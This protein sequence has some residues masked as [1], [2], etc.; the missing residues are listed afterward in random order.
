MSLVREELI[1]RETADAILMQEH[2]G[3]FVWIGDSI[4]S[5]EKE[6]I[7]FLT[8]YIERSPINL[9][10][11]SLE[12]DTV[13]VRNDNEQVPSGRFSPLEFLAELSLQ[14][15]NVYESTLRYYGVF[16]YRARGDKRSA[17]LK[18][19]SEEEQAL[20]SENCL[21]ELE[22]RKRPSPSWAQC[23]RK[24]YE[25]DP[26]LCPRCGGNMKIVSAIVD[27][28]EVERIATNLGYE[29]YH[30]PPPIQIATSDVCN[31]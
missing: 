12:G 31:L 19:L 23:I 8:R 17:E 26:L 21:S 10:K 6:R 24:T 5:T 28:K 27:E 2:T 4:P 15:P 13:V 9:Q 29:K 14:I 18:Q 30:P 20:I 25:L 7:K 11:L 22:P 1:E 16:S 3:F